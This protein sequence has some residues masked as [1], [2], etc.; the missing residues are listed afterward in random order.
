MA[1]LNLGKFSTMQIHHPW[2]VLNDAIRPIQGPP[3]SY[4]GGEERANEKEKE[5]E[6]ARD[7]QLQ[8]NLACKRS[9]Q[10]KAQP[11]EETAIDRISN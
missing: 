7:L 11:E 8:G 6:G 2:Q 4:C 9:I 5:K 3:R 10:P 1:T